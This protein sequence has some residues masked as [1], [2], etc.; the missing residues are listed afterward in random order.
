MPVAPSYH[1]DLILIVTSSQR[2]SMINSLKV[3]TIHTYCLILLDYYVLFC[4]QHL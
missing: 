4:L 2:L 1:S 3:A